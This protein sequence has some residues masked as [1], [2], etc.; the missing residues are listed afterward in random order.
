MYSNYSNLKVP[1]KN[2]RMNTIGQISNLLENS[3]KKI[4]EQQKIFTNLFQ[5]HKR[6]TG[7]LPKV[8]LDKHFQYFYQ[9]TKVK[10]LQIEK[11]FI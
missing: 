10:F 3:L 1:D 8:N 5:I 11:L 9:K 7:Y 2:A 6:G 4:L